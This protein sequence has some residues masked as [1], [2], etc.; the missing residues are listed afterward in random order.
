MKKHIFASLFALLAVI[1]SPTQSAAQ[2]DVASLY[3]K[4]ITE[5]LE[6]QQQLKDKD[7]EISKL[8]GQLNDKVKEVADNEKELV[9]LQKQLSDA[10]QKIEDLKTRN[11]ELEDSSKQDKKALAEKE[12][13]SL[14]KENARLTAQLA[15]LTKERDSVRS[16]NNDLLVV[17]AEIIKQRETEFIALAQRPFSSFNQSD[18]VKA[19]QECEP[20]KK[21]LERTYELLSRAKEGKRLYD[22]AIAQTKKMYLKPE[23]ESVRTLLSSRIVDAPDT[24]SQ[25]KELEEL[26]KLFR[27]YADGIQM[28]KD[29]IEE[30]RSNRMVKVHQENN[31]KESAID[32]IRTK[33]FEDPG[34]KEG[35]E[36]TINIVPF[37]KEYFATFQQKVLTE[38]F[39]VSEE[40]AALQ[41][42]QL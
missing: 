23:V 7:T 12:G 22:L 34:Y 20:F 21:D 14:K 17:K 9:K 33:I 38:P 36:N 4:V 37:L 41:A 2:T 31:D 35:I 29:F 40:E 8:N 13:N 5:K 19:L 39:V 11:K 6:L 26:N 3:E 27:T 42:V 18:L 30:I 25:I 28:S 24:P 1:A 32:Y 15:A 10:T 16:E